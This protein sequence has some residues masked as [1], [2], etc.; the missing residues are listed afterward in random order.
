MLVAGAG[1]AELVA[2]AGMDDAPELLEHAPSSA[3]AYITTGIKNAEPGPRSSH[4]VT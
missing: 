4:A 1:G 2:M 3:A